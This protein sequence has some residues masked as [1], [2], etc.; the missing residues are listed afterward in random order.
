MGCGVF[1]V[2]VFFCL[3]VCFQWCNSFNYLSGMESL[4]SEDS[5]SKEAA[6]LSRTLRS[7]SL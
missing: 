6:A 7:C 4:L 2:G 1:F 3:L 5:K